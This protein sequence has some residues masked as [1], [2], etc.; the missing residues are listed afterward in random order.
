MPISTSYQQL[1]ILEI[2][3]SGKGLTDI[4]PNI[5]DWLRS[6]GIDLGILHLTCLHTSASLTVN[7]NADPRV[8]QDLSAF[9]S[10]LVPENGFALPNNKGA[11]LTY[12]H[13]E[14]GPDDMPAH[15]KTALTTAAL[16]L[17]LHEGRLLL[18]AWQSVYLWEH[19]SQPRRRQIAMH[20]IG[21]LSH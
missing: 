5:D 12:Q 14:E 20:A 11:C 9:F 17:S 2:Q 13:N 10:A 1:K 18:G 21:K 15:I 6:T 19:R 16:S 3:T 4:T 7:E 8:L